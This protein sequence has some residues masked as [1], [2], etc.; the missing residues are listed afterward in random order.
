MSE[1]FATAY[2]SLA[3][4]PDIDGDRI[5]ACGRSL[6]GAAVCDLAANRPVASLIL[7]S[8]FTNLRAMARRF[9]VPG[10]LVRDPFDNLA[11]VRSYPKPVLVVHGARDGLIPHRHGEQ[12]ASAAPHGR[13]VSYPCGHN[14]CPPDWDQFWMEVEQFLDAERTR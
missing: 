1:T 5:S 2:D 4:Q 14:D 6:G 13:L 12:L 7:L 9:R 3:A 11:V 10:V 8:T